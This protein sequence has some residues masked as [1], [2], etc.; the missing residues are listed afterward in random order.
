MTTSLS[1]RAMLRIALDYATRGWAVLPVHTVVHGECTCGRTK[2]STPGKHPRVSWRDYL[3][4]APSI[5]QVRAWFG[6][7]FYGSNLGL[8]TGRVSGLVV[9]DCDGPEGIDSAESLELPRF[10]LT[11][12]T[13]GGGLHRMYRLADSVVPSKRGALKK[14]DIKAEGG[15]V[16]LP[17]SLHASGRRYRWRY[18]IRAVPCDLGVLAQPERSGDPNEPAWFSELLEGV[19]EGERSVAA[20]RLVGRYLNLGLSADEVWMLLE[21]WNTRNTP[22]LSQTDLRGTLRSLLRKHRETIDESQQLES[23]PSIIK[24]LKSLDLL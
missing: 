21:N 17:P 5:A 24:S 12:R 6:D 1:N 11:A 14:V 13:G 8:V 9:V 15:F 23:L 20:S 3:E 10:T 22:P 4:T 7:E 2:C 16:V 18:W 19:A